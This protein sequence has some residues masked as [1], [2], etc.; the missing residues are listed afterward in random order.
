MFHPEF[1]SHISHKIHNWKS[2]ST[3][4]WAD[5]PVIDI[6]RVEEY[7]C[8][9][10]FRFNSIFISLQRTKHAA[11]LTTLG[12]E[13]NPEL[14]G[15]WEHIRDLGLGAL[16]HANRHAAYAAIENGRWPDLAVLQAAHAAELLIKARIAQEHPL[17]I[18]EELPRSTQAAGPLLS[19]EDLFK[20]GH[21]LQWSDLPE[22]LWAAT[23]ISLANQTAFEQFG[24]YRNGIQH[25]ASPPGQ[26]PSE[27]T[28]KFTFSVIDPFINSCWGLFA[29]DYDED[30]EP[31][32]YFIDALVSREILF[33][34]SPE[35]ATTFDEWAVDWQDVTPAYRDEMHRRAKA[36]KTPR[37]S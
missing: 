20:K 29:V 8:C 31:Y 28:L 26:D 23:G 33:L 10:L 6:A 9:R 34:V 25:F 30:Y 13:M 14:K 36:I 21:T 24:K 16:A 12:A 17:L 11:G 2:Y 5:S 1:D 22:R 4:D 37:N 19:L 35:A 7:S 3:A 15:I 27:E 18:F 32:V